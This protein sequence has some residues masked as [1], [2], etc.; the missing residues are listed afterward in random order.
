MPEHKGWKTDRT[1]WVVEEA[2]SWRQGE[3]K[4]ERRFPRGDLERGKQLKYK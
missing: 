4:W 2:P 3:G 1:G